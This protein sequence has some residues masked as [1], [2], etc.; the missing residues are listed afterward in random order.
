MKRLGANGR[1]LAIV[2]QLGPLLGPVLLATAPIL[3]LFAHNESDIALSLIWKPL[4]IAALT[5]GVLYAISLIIVKRG[6]RAAVLTSVVTVAFFYYGPF[7][8]TT[9]GW[10]LP[11]ATLL[12]LWLTLFALGV[13]GVLRARSGLRNVALILGAAAA[14][15]IVSPVVRIVAYRIEHPAVR[16]SDSRLWPTPVPKPVGTQGGTRPD[17]YYIIPDD[18][19]RADTLKKS[20]GYDNSGFIRQLRARGFAIQD[21]VRS[22][23]SK[24]EFN[25]ASAL[26][27]DYLN[28]L[29]K[30]LGQD[31][32]DVLLVRKMIDDSRAS[33]FLKSL[34]Y[35]YIHL[36]SDNI[37]FGAD[38]P[39]L[40]PLAAPDN[41]TYQWL[42]GTLLREFDGG[43]GFSQVATDERFRQSVRS[44][45]KKL[46]ATAAVPSP[47]FV[48]FHTLLPHDPYIF[49]PRGQSV[50]FPDQSDTGHSTRRGIKFYVKQLEFLNQKLLQT[51]DAISAHAK[52]PPIIV[53][54]SDE[55]FEARPE[56]FGEAAVRDIRVKGLSAFH[57]P[58][59][60]AARPPR[61]LNTVNTFRFLFDRYFGAHL[62]PLRGATH[63][64]GDAPY[65]FE[66]MPVR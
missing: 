8:N 51:V 61:D 36:D 14:V 11:H 47:K 59:K 28:R 24:S 56:D 66:E 54:Q 52:T 60:N 6:T 55:G 19:A 62:G 23:Y 27:L 10:S 17:V 3:S 43:L 16:T 48:V 38:N 49:G 34:N 31:S 7:Y 45:F 25:M 15:S 42:R 32:Q 37:T 12:P 65:R 5:A 46:V 39:H 40:S 29:P 50:R 53:I 30:V 2:R 20:F 64:E 4:A 13:F 35:R 21:Q 26:N 18:Y 22:P 58:G 63:P 9:S 44:A 41:L 57:L 33:H 1:P